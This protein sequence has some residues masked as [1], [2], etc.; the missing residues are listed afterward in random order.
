LLS[1]IS[2]RG[3]N[4]G[5]YIGYDIG[6]ISVNRVILNDGGKIVETLP[7]CRH[8]GE[9]LK[10]VGNDLGSIAKRTDLEE[11]YGIGFTGSGGKNIA[12]LFNSVF[13]NEI[14]A[15]I[16]SIKYLHKEA[17]TVIEIGGQD[18]KFIDLTIG[19]YAMNELCA[20]GTGSFLDQQ[21]T[22]FGL[23]I[24]EF[25]DLA[26]KSKNPS[27]IAGRCSVF[28]KTDMIHLQQEAAKDEDIALGLCYAMARS[29]KSGIV[30]GKKFIPPIIFCGGVSFNKAM[31]KAFEEVL[32]EKLIIPK[33][34]ESV[35]AA[36]AALSLR[37]NAIK[38]DIDISM[39][40]KKLDDYLKNFIYKKETFKVLNLVK[41]KLPSNAQEKY[42]FDNGEVDAYIG[43]DV[44]SISTN[45]VAVDKDKKLIAKC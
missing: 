37:T 18:S 32:R 26:L 27:A 14:E 17:K 28:A 1:I 25:V 2:K 45:V 15:I 22:R 11:I 12:K 9:P 29:F 38:K 13:V 16:T 24:E 31:I 20:A 3:D 23:T 36:G 33:D 35:G 40:L 5:F 44:G 19:D 42:N 34:R 6:S 39:L 4:L 41:S 7:Y 43:I 30:K 10:I 21:A 8:N